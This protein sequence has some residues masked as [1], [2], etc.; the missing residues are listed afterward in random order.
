MKLPKF[1]DDIAWYKQAIDEIADVN[2]IE[3]A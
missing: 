1:M 2:F 3:W